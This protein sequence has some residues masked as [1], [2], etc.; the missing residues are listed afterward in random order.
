MTVNVV[1]PGLVDTDMIPADP[2]VREQLAATRTVGR[3]GT[4]EEV[5]DLVAAVVAN[6]YLSNQSIVIDGGT[7][8]T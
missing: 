2:T 5:A 7:L 8:P 4:V 3:L 6:A 1:A